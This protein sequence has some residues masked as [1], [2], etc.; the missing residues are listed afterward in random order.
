M[1]Y[2]VR[3]NEQIMTDL[4]WPVGTSTSKCFLVF[5]IISKTEATITSY[6]SQSPNIFTLDAYNTNEALSC[7]FTK[8]S[9]VYCFLRMLDN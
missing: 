4:P 9:A 6:Q 2:R 7:L 3:A 5:L 1:S 8:V